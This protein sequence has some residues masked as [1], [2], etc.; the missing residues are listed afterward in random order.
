MLYGKGDFQE[1]IKYAFNFGWDADCNAATVGTIIGVTYGY[2]RMMNPND[3]F[4]PEWQIVDRY[5][6]TT[7]DNMPMDETI[8]S[9][10]DRLVELFEMVNEANG[11]KKTLV[12]N[13]VVYQIP[14]EQPATI[15]KLSSIEEQK[16]MMQKEF[17]SQIIHDLTNGNREEKA[18]AAYLAICLDL[19]AS[20]AKSNAKQWKEACYDLSGYWKIMNNIF[21]D[22]R[23]DFTTLNLFQKKFETAGIKIPSKAYT[24]DE[25]FNDQIFWKDPVELYK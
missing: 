5:K 23:H 3:R 17:E 18:R 13:T 25:M 7:R 14:V 15:I 10:S 2:R 19:N 11:G 4:N 21:H 8:T 6:N 1:S 24:A 12:N 16:Q 22:V 9:F 20:L